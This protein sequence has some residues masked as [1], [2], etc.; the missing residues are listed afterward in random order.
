MKN[1]DKYGYP[2]NTHFEGQLT[3]KT[4]LGFVCTVGIYALV[5]VAVIVMGSDFVNST[6]QSEKFSSEKFDRHMSENYY[7]SENQVAFYLFPYVW[8]ADKVEALPP[9]IGKYTLK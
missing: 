2:I 8:N 7:L 1:L 9:E 5:M 6:R 3:Y 4:W